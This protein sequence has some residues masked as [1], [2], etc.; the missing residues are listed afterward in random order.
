MTGPA[1]ELRDAMRGAN[2]RTALMLA[3]PFPPFAQSTG[4]LR[5]VSFV[6]HLPE[7]GW[8]PIVVTG[9]TS[10]YPAVDARTE[11]EIPAGTTVMRAW[12]KDVARHFS[13]RG[14]YPRWLATP[15]RWNT[16]ALGA[17]RVAQRAVREFRPEVLWAT[18]PVPS[19]LL[20]ALIAQRRTG[21]PLVADLRDPLVYETW[22]AKCWERAVYGWIERR[23]VAHAAAIV[24]TT[25][26]A[27]A[28]Y[29]ERYPHAAEK[30]VVIANGIDESDVAPPA[31][32]TR[33]PNGPLLLVHSGLMESPDRDPTV[34][35]A[36]LRLLRERGCLP[37]RGLR[38][39]LR[40]SGSEVAYRARAQAQ[41]VS[42]LLEL[43]PPV[44][45]AEAIREQ[46][47]ADGLLLFQGRHC[48]RQIP[49]KAY[50]YLAGGR[51]IIGLMDAGGDT[52][53]LVAGA[54][55]VPYC[56]DMESAEAIAAM[57]ERF[58]DDA[59]RGTVFV[60]AAELREAH[61]RRARAT[62]LAQLFDKVRARR[63]A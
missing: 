53:A 4:R 2:S 42:D 10:M 44:A 41:G 36:A 54:W 30:F 23:L 43:A 40:A 50:E 21:I 32:R 46:A 19:A 48:N 26:G 18:F 52:H 9:V 24:V 63:P 55:R 61:S 35:F 8:R 29:V 5:T 20:A 3:F 38:V 47:A 33:E 14:I 1:P 27:R 17:V 13:I 45:R 22:P 34:F 31:A 59:A 39:V 25:P 62:E 58:F 37:A 28:M 49:A 51:P 11:R 16:W 15:D 60:P 57:L 12:G 56:A 7:S 6:R